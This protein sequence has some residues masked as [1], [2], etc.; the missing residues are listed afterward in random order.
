MVS[1]DNKFHAKYFQPEGWSLEDPQPSDS[2]TYKGTH[3]ATCDTIEEIQQAINDDYHN[4][5]DDDF[6][7]YE[8]Y[9]PQEFLD[10]QKAD[11]NR[12]NLEFANDCPF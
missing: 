9:F 2:K 5:P 12:R 3:V 6:G 1:P 11:L 7:F 4:H 10:Q 8:I